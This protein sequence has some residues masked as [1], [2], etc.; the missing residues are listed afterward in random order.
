MANE[1]ILAIWRTTTSLVEQVKEYVNAGYTNTKDSSGIN[2]ILKN[3]KAEDND[4][5]KK[6]EVIENPG[7]DF[8]SSA[9]VEEDIE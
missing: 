1:D 9:L 2:K 6:T 4:E 8:D 3:S 5:P 7:K